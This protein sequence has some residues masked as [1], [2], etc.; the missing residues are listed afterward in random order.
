M[1][2]FV[3]SGFFLYFF[4]FDWFVDR[5]GSFDAIRLIGFDWVIALICSNGLNGWIDVIGSLILIDA[6][7]LLGFSWI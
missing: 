2:L 4:Y 5:I 7:I 6:L 3:L 1:V